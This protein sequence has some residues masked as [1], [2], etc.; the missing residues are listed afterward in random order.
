M[1]G[2]TVHILH[3]IVPECFLS[4]LL[5]KDGIPERETSLYLI[6]IMR[7]LSRDIYM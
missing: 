6:E 5:D 2:H 3:A 1:L 7:S 4:V